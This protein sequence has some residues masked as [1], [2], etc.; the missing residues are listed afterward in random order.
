VLEVS[1]TGTGMTEEVRQ[2]CLE[3]FFSTK[4]K[5]GTGLGLSLVHATIE[6]HR[7][8]LSIDS[9]PGRG[10]TFVVRLP[11]RG[12][13][14]TASTPIEVPEPSQR[15]HVLVVDDDALAMQSVVAQLKTQ[16]H[17]IETAPNGR[18]GLARFLSG[19]VDGGRFDLVVT[20]RA[21]PEMGGDQM[22]SLIERS[23]MGAPVIMLTGFGDLM[24]AKGEQPPGVH[25]VLSKPVTL[26]AL[27]QAIRKAT[28]NTPAPR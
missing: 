2:R 24:A 27:A 11:R 23:G 15:L 5:Q 28:A 17:R 20:D 10:S 21:M 14:G 22:A 16:G 25:A 18:E 7:G 12:K 1:D 6:R 9:Q 19:T 8:T 4:G 3:P 26:N 13:M